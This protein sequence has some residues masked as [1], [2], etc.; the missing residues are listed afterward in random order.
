MYSNLFWTAWPED[1][2][3]QLLQNVRNCSPIDTVAHTKHLNLLK[4]MQVFLS[5]LVKHIHDAQTDPKFS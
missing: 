4:I 1:E 3:T 2:G 5:L